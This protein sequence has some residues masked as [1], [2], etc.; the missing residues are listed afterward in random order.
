METALADLPRI[1]RLA[2]AF[3]SRLRRGTLD[4]TLPDGRVIR[5]GGHEPGP[6]ATR[7]LHNYGFAS[8]L[9][10]GGDIG[11]AEKVEIR[12]Q[13]YRD[14]RDRY[15]RIASIEMIEAVG[16]QFWP[17]YFAQL[18]DRLPTG[19]LAGIQAITIQDRLFQGYRARSTSSS[20]TSFPAACC[21][22]PPC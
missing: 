16:E 11:L 7:R 22:R 5:L 13:D 14:E 15:D 6:N 3:G 10:N 17:R 1:V 21:P 12:L 18:R 4:V 8:R 2:L 9:I 20:A 19:G